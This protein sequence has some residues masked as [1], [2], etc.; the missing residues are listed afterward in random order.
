V[1][2]FDPAIPSKVPDADA[3]VAT[4][5]ET[6]EWVRGFPASAGRGYYLVQ[7]YEAWTEMIRPRVDATWR[8][9]LRKIVIAG[10]LERFALERFGERVWARIPN[11]VDAARF[12]PPAHRGGPPFTV[13]ML[14]DLSVHKGAD[15]GVAAL[16]RIHEAVPET[17]FVLFGRARLRHRLPPRTRYV[18]DPRQADLPDVYG[19]FDLFLNAS[20]SEGF[21]LVILEAMACGCATVATAVGETPEMGEPGREYAMAPAGQPGLLADQAITL[22]RDPQRLRAMAAAGLDRA[23]AYDWQ[24]AT[25]RF[26]SAL[27]RDS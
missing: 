27:K 24:T 15:D 17:S 25:D 9:P 18:R 12:R 22:L 26:E 6:A 21:S 10:W 8:L 5:W 2:W 7:Q 20:H 4:A 16:W 23:R 1:R 19:S 11:G 3:V 13:G 14:Y